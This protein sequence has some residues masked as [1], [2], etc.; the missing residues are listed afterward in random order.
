MVI[1]IARCDYNIYARAYR[2]E[3][4]VVREVADAV[5]E[6]YWLEVP[7]NIASTEADFKASVELLIERASD[8]SRK[9][10]DFSGLSWSVGSSVA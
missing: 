8:K 3:A 10:Q 9:I 2:V 1:H 6:T 7:E 4:D 5:T